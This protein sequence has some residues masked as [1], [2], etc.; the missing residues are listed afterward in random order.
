MDTYLKG[1]LAGIELSIN[2][3]EA[4]KKRNPQLENALDFTIM[5]IRRVQEL[6]LK[7]MSEDKDEED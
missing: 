7:E 3:M 4:L 2:V 1:A 5:E 6:A